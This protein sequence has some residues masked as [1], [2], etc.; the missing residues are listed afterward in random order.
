[1]HGQ[2]EKVLAIANGH[3]QWEV[4]ISE[5]MANRTQVQR[6]A[7]REAIAPHTW[8]ARVETLSRFLEETLNATANRGANR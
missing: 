4:A 2:F 1:M 6:D 3:E 5:Q 7:R 8:D